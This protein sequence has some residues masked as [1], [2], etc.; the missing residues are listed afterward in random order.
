MNNIT[1]HYNDQ[2]IRL[3]LFNDFYITCAFKKDFTDDVES[4][5][6]ALQDG[7][8]IQKWIDKTGISFTISFNGDNIPLDKFSTDLFLIENEAV[9]TDSDEGGYHVD[10]LDAD[11]MITHDEHYETMKEVKQACADYIK[12]GRFVDCRLSTLLK[13]GV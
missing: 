10:F 2:D 3:Q 12:I 6:A 8:R 5:L 1:L 7:R 11:D 9:L 4:I 13:K